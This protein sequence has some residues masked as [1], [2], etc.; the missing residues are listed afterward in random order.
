MFLNQ[1]ELNILQKYSG[2]NVNAFS[3]DKLEEAFRIFDEILEGLDEYGIRELMGG[4]EKD[5][6]EI[7]SIIFESIISTLYGNDP[8]LGDKLSYLDHVSEQVEEILS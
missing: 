7:W 4:G 8:S 2:N 5:I 3:N 1:S 6:E